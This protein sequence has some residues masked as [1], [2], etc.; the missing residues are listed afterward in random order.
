MG[1][2]YGA[3]PRGLVIA[4]HGDHVFVLIKLTIVP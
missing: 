3:G 1:L 2:R 4:V